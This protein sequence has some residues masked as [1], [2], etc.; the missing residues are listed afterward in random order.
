MFKLFM[1]VDGYCKNKVMYFNDFKSALDRAFSHCD[2]WEKDKNL[3]FASMQSAKVSTDNK[4][5]FTMVGV[6]YSELSEM[7][8][9]YGYVEIIEVDFNPIESTF[10]ELMLD[11]GYYSTIICGNDKNET[12]L[13]YFNTSNEAEE[14]GNNLDYYKSWKDGYS[15]LDFSGAYLF[16]YNRT[17]L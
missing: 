1:N 11:N 16:I 8:S 12:S 14:Y 4:T 13:G 2:I 15:G 6:P 3:L 9:Q 5:Y 17:I 7:D 10:C